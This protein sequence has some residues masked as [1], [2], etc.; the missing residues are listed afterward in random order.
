MKPF[1]TEQTMAPILTFAGG[2]HRVDAFA[3]PCLQ[4]GIPVG[5]LQFFGRAYLFWPNTVWYGVAGFEVHAA[6]ESGDHQPESCLLPSRRA[7]LAI[8]RTRPN[9]PES[10]AAP[11]HS[12][13]SCL[14]TSL[15]RTYHHQKAYYQVKPAF[16][17]TMHSFRCSHSTFLAQ[18]VQLEP[19]STSHWM[20]YLDIHLPSSFR[21]QHCSFLRLWLDVEASCLHD[22]TCLGG[23]C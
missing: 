21:G 2:D 14:F 20:S 22:L 23:P 16:R 15:P 10:S 3:G 11:R 13:R 19:R 12:L 7:L 5:Q 4:Q 6:F 17:A 9:G 1:W 8:T 18:R